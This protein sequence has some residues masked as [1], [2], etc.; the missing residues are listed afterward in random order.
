MAHPII[1][2]RVMSNKISKQFKKIQ[3][4]ESKI[5]EFNH[6]IIID[7]NKYTLKPG[8]K[9]FS[10]K[11]MSSTEFSSFKS[12]KFPLYIRIRLNLLMNKIKSESDVLLEINIQ[13]LDIFKSK[14]SEGVAQNKDSEYLI[15]LY[16]DF[17]RHYDFYYYYGDE[18][19]PDLFNILYNVFFC[20]LPIKLGPNH[21]GDDIDFY[22]YFYNT[23][24][25]PNFC[26]GFVFVFTKKITKTKKEGVGYNCSTKTISTSF[27]LDS[28]NFDHFTIHG[29]TQTQ[30]DS[31]KE[32]CEKIKQKKKESPVSAH[33][34]FK[35]VH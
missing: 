21:Y 26:E 18:K 10:W 7:G 14:F 2:F 5:Q 27:Y 31:L 11:H 28:E 13:L 12:E 34:Y 20:V 17:Y 23:N 30:I 32:R 24:K 19:I 22:K 29:F 9:Y 25:W 4:I 6:V 3:A 1:E 16:S 33:F 15:E 35:L 8:Y